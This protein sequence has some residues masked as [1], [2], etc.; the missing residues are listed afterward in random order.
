MRRPVIRAVLEM[1]RV[2]LGIVDWDGN[3]SRSTSVEGSDGRGAD[4]DVDEGDEGEDEAGGDVDEDVD[5]MGIGYGVGMGSSGGSGNTNSRRF[6]AGAGTTV[7]RT[8]RT[9]ARTRSGRTPGGITG[10]RK[11]LIDAG[12]VGTLRR[13]VDHHPSQ[14]HSS[15]TLHYA[16]HV[17]HSHPHSVSH[18]AS[19][20]SGT[21]GHNVESIGPGHGHGHGSSLHVHYGS[22]GSSSIPAGVAGDASFGIGSLSSIGMGIGTGISGNQGILGREDREDLDTAKMALDWL[23]YGEMYAYAWSSTSSTANVAGVGRARVGMRSGS[24]DASD[25]GSSRGRGGES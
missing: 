15:S 6:G 25:I 2:D 21:T 20:S 23:E 7:S 1:V 11:I 13:I 14:S 8:Q 17:P 10:A 12:F 19:S 5:V 18:T 22:L 3:S 16:S 9:P 24:V 4:E